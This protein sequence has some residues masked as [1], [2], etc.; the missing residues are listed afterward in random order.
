MSKLKWELED[1]SLRY[2][3]P[4]NYYDLVDKVSKKR[5]EREAYIE[6]VIKVLYEKL[7]EVNIKCEISGRPKNFYSIYKKNRCIRVKLL[8]KYMT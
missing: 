3:D 1:L 6:E 7:E 2:L 5:R 8:K 4:D